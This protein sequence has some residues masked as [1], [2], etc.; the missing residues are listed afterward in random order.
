MSYCLGFVQA[1]TL[2][3]RTFQLGCPCNQFAVSPLVVLLLFERTVVV[4]FPLQVMISSLS[5]VPFKYAHECE[6]LGFGA[7]V[8]SSYLGVYGKVVKKEILWMKSLGC[9][10]W[11]GLVPMPGEFL[12]IV[13][14]DH[15]DSKS[16]GL[17]VVI[18]WIASSI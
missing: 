8:L 4:A 10:G 6:Q 15:S 5:L 11:E 12:G 9:R 13:G 14:Q 7:H 2:L 18:F 17:L 1:M 16:S 3:T